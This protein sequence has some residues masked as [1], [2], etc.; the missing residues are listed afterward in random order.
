MLGFLAMCL[1]GRAAPLFERTAKGLNHTKN[2]K[3]QI[4]AEKG[5]WPAY[6]LRMKL[7]K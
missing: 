7:Q 3:H 6:S 5:Q 2:K 4:E 1:L